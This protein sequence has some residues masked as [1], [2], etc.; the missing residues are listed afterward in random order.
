MDASSDLDSLFGEFNRFLNNELTKTNYHYV[1]IGRNI[2][3][4]LEV[5][6]SCR[7]DAGLAMLRPADIARLT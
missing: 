3:R 4:D 5:I 7:Q 2:I 1:H 6:M